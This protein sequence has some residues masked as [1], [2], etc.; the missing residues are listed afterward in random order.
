MTDPSRL[1]GLQCILTNDWCVIPI[2]IKDGLQYVALCPFN[3][4]EWESLPHVILKGSTDWDPGVPYIDLHDNGMPYLT[5][6][7]TSL[8]LPLMRLAIT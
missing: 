1:L 4:E 3:D 2:S 6:L 5:C 7:W 8:P